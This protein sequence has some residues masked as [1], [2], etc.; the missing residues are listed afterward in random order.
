MIPEKVETVLSEAL[1]ACCDIFKAKTAP[2]NVEH[3]QFIV[4]GYSEIG[5]EYHSRMDSDSA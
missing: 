3:N 5:N 2:K 4:T 1:S